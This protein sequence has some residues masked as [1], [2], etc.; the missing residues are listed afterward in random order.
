MYTFSREGGG[1][2]YSKRKEFAPLVSKFLT[3]RVDPLSVDVQKSKQDI[4][5][6]VSLVKMAE[7]LPGVFQEP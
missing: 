3:Y 4:T 1:G 2:I 7:N 5:K 6:V